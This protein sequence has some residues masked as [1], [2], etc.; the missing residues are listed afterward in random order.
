MKIHRGNALILFHRSKGEI[1]TRAHVFVLETLFYQWRM[2]NQDHVSLFFCVRVSSD[3]GLL[4]S[5]SIQRF[6]GRDTETNL[7]DPADVDW[8]REK[9]VT[10]MKIIN[11]NMK[12]FSVGDVDPFISFESRTR[13][14]KR[15]CCPKVVMFYSSESIMLME[16][17]EEKEKS[18][19]LSCPSHFSSSSIMHTVTRTSLKIKKES[20]REREREREIHMWGRFVR[21]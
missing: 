18:W 9:P 2:S 8:E 15:E 17:E 11:Q 21:L 12:F 20:H 3:L 5:I 6:V 4:R 16:C 7:R 13:Q 14:R 1:R 10:M 19:D